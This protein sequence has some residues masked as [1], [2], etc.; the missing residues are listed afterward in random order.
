ME[1]FF[2]I[3]VILL[4]IFAMIYN[5]T[6]KEGVTS[7]IETKGEIETRFRND[8]INFFKKKD[9]S[10]KTDCK[11]T[12][13]NKMVNG[14]LEKVG[15]CEFFSGKE[16]FTP[17][18]KTMEQTQYTQAINQCEMLN[19]TLVGIDINDGDGHDS[20]ISKLRQIP[21]MTT[22]IISLDE[23]GK[24]DGEE[25]DKGCGYCYE[26]GGVGKILYGDSLGPFKNVKT[27]NVCETWIKPGD[28][29]RGGGSNLKKNNWE[30]SSEAKISPQLMEF[31]GNQG[32][33][34]DAVKLHEQEICSRVT[35]CGD[36]DNEKKICGWCFMGRDGKGEGEGMVKMSDG[37]GET[38]YMDDYCPWPG[39][40]VIDENDNSKITDKWTGPGATSKWLKT[41]GEKPITD[42]QIKKIDL[43]LQEDKENRLNATINDDSLDVSVRGFA[44]KALT[45]VKKVWEAITRNGEGSE[46]THVKNG[47]KYETWKTDG[48]ETNNKFLYRCGTDKTKTFFLHSYYDLTEDQKKVINAVRETHE[49]YKK[50]QRK[51][52]IMGTV[53]DDNE[54]KLC[55]KFHTALNQPEN[56]KF[57]TFFMELD[58]SKEKVGC[59]ENCSA[60]CIPLND[61]DISGVMGHDANNNDDDFMGKAVYNSFTETPKVLTQFVTPNV[62]F[63]S[64]YE[65]L[66]KWGKITGNQSLISDLAETKLAETKL[67]NNK[68][69][70]TVFIDLV[71]KK[72]PSVFLKDIK[73]SKNKVIG[74]GQ[75]NTKANLTKMEEDETIEL[76]DTWRKLGGKR[77]MTSNEDCSALDENFPCFKNW[78]GNKK[79]AD[80]TNLG[81][82]DECYDELWRTQ[83]KYDEAK[84]VFDDGCSSFGSTSFKTQ[85]QKAFKSKDN[86]WTNLYQYTI[87]LMNKKGI[88][89]VKEDIKGI[90]T[91]ADTSNQYESYFTTAEDIGN[92][93]NNSA[94]A[95]TLA[96]YGKETELD[97]ANP[98]R[99]DYKKMPYSCDNR[100]RLPTRNFPR[101]RSCIDYYWK[102]HTSRLTHF[103]TGG[104]TNKA[105][106]MKGKNWHTF[107]PS[108]NPN[109]P[110]AEKNLVWGMKWLPSNMF[111]DKIHFTLS[112][113]ALDAELVKMVANINGFNAEANKRGS[114]IAELY[115]QY[116]LNRML[117]CEY[118]Y[119][120]DKIWV[121]LSGVVFGDDFG[122]TIEKVWVKMCWGDFKD[123][124]ISLDKNVS[125]SADGSLDLSDSTLKDII[126]G[127]KNGLSRKILETPDEFDDGIN[128]G[129]RV[130]T[131]GAIKFE[132]KDTPAVTAELYNKT[133]FPFWR[134][135][136]THLEFFDKVKF[137]AKEKDMRDKRIEDQKI[138]TE[139]GCRIYADKLGKNLG[140][141][142]PFN[143][144]VGNKNCFYYT[145]GDLDGNA[146]FNT[147]KIPDVAMD[148]PVFVGDP[149]FVNDS[150]NNFQYTCSTGDTY[151]TYN[152][153]TLTP[154]QKQEVRDSWPGKPPKHYACVQGCR[155]KCRKN[156]V[157]VMSNV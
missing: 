57:K 22:Q 86:K 128:F 72:N 24:P 52:S 120:V 129:K 70:W 123:A 4:L 96:C 136:K 5:S 37:T 122:G 89:F 148:D 74:N 46:T 20:L 116:L 8:Q 135:F 10:I 69:M 35:G 109:P 153:N 91:I 125:V 143:G 2:F 132:R 67:A 98:F 118:L 55:N 150:A 43:Q 19:K 146:Y 112:N 48:A 54:I 142:K 131:G 17:M 42:D 124:V 21:E 23:N 80:G 16:T 99:P 87:P 31:G 44:K 38:K 60:G 100:F 105:W 28:I 104:D 130:N 76:K 92:Q 102:K 14:E 154:T 81:H 6:N 79:K 95:A 45:G 152:A 134:F 121:D 68:K 29:S 84:K 56:T 27:G 11:D 85:M 144:N 139:S 39:E 78:F 50:C 64:I 110:D 145:S 82:T 113:E 147:N 117:L 49:F 63:D 93:I 111:K 119:D 40:V 41:A 157:G 106:W 62:P 58:F 107:N 13:F 77:L 71:K 127:T 103:L 51:M 15:V 73:L 151:A 138:G 53:Q 156:G 7:S 33:I 61:E 126:N 75:L 36:L 94:K 34:N 133:W 59:L 66:L 90:R 115:D 3:I 12:E 114:N 88:P 18:L 137:N 30:G 155:G 25:D 83:T 97:D 108:Y 1:T 9:K 141:G 65:I 47:G 149:V 26:K 101:P 140:G 32:V